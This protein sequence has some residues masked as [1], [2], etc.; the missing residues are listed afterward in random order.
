MMRAGKMSAAAV[1]VPTD[2]EMSAAEMAATEVATAK[3]AATE[4]SAAA[5]SA[6]PAMTSAAV[7]AATAPTK[8]A[9]G[10]DDRKHGGCHD[11]P[12]HWHTPADFPAREVTGN[13]TESSRAFI[14]A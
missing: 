2:M 6:A 11:K 10:K 4:M 14:W 1:K 13:G 8:C 5:M 9:A 3:M 12:R 7:S